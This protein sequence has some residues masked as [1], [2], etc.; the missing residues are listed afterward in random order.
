MNLE[1]S[2]LNDVLILII[3]RAIIAKNEIK[4]ENSSDEERSFNE[5]RALAYYEVVST[6][7]G[8]AAAFGL[9]SDIIPALTFNAEKEL[10]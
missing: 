9:T 8:Q 1:Q 7:L 5:G 6:F 2:Y 10:L 4:D 3:E